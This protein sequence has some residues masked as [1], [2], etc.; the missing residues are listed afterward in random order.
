MNNS[1]SNI[2]FSTPYEYNDKG[3]PEFMKALRN[4]SDTVSQIVFNPNK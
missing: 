3:E 1:Y 2:N 4:H